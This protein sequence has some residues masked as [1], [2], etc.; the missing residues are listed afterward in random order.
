[1]SFV[2]FSILWIGSSPSILSFVYCFSRLYIVS[3]VCQLFRL[4]IVSQ[5]HYGEIFGS[6]GSG[7]ECYG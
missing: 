5:T 1:M 4:S 6:D 3:L 7:M 2:E